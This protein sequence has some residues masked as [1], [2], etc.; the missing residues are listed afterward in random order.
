MRNFLFFFLV[1]F[2]I[3]FSQDSSFVLLPKDSASV[4]TTSIDTTLK[5]TPVDTASIDTTL[6]PT[7]VDTAT[8]DSAKIKPGLHFFVSTG[9]QFIT[10]KKRST[11]QNLLISKYNE[12][13][14]DYKADTA[15]HTP[16]IKQ[17]F[18]TV[19]LVF[20]ISAGIIWQF[21]DVHSL[22][23]GAGFLYNSESVILT[24]K[25]SKIHNF[26]YT[27]KALPVFAEYRLLISPNLIS[28][29]DNDYFSL[30]LRYYWLLPP[31]EINSSWG[32]AKADFEPLGNGYGMFFGYR[33]W[34]W[35]NLSVFGEMGLL[36]IDAKSSSK[37]R[38]LDS[39]N[40]GG[41]SILIRALF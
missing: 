3:V 32:K 13:E 2:G 24:D 8:S 1:F 16:P 18:E 14:K 29:R 6:K 31:T 19:N 5:A 39:W 34:E 30:F 22:S 41:I 23:L 28:L 26:K 38:V 25:E 21:S 10:F 9:A 15:G 35:M 36:S 4:D 11:F 37:D 12:Y 20:P 27:I 17:D 40:L 33:F 7:P